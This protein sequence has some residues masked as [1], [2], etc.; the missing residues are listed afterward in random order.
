MYF[1]VITLDYM[2][3]GTLETVDNA[4]GKVES[5]LERHRKRKEKV[6]LLSICS[7]MFQMTLRIE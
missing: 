6:R 5:Q 4:E 7:V 1:C 2:Y 3:L